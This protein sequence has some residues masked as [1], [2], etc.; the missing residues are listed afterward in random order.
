[1]VLI[2]ISPDGG[3]RRVFVQP[4][5]VHK[6][7]EQ[8]NPSNDEYLVLMYDAK[9]NIINEESFLTQAESGAFISR[10]CDLLDREQEAWARTLKPL[11][12]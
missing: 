7:I 5:A 8:L 2:Q 3:T 9:G 12:R 10:I 11:K 1:M 6:I 4:S